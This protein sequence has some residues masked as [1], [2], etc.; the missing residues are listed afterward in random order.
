MLKTFNLREYFLGNYAMLYYDRV[1]VALRGFPK[2]DVSLTEIP[3]Q[4]EISK[5]FPP[6]IKRDRFNVYTGNNVK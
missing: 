4:S 5:Y 1:R 6:S 2:L 3:L